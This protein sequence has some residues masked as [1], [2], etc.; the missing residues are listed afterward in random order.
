MTYRRC[1]HNDARSRWLF[2]FDLI[3]VPVD[4]RAAN[5]FPSAPRRDAVITPLFFSSRNR[6]RD[7]LRGSL[8][9]ATRH[10][11][12]RLAGFSGG[13]RSAWE[14]TVSLRYR[15]ASCR[16][17]TRPRRARAHAHGRPP[18]GR[19]HNH[20]VWDERFEQSPPP[21]PRADWLFAPARRVPRCRTRVSSRAR[22]HVFRRLY[23]CRRLVIA[24]TRGHGSPRS[25]RVFRGERLVIEYLE[26]TAMIILIVVRYDVFG[27]GRSTSP[28][29]RRRRP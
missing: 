12:P 17:V 11:R 14:A 22:D 19:V 21:P 5:D 9:T 4:R 20:R 2:L 25:A 7:G 3:R 6:K 1:Q 15:A 27:P 10:A 16:H 23:H 18:R 24:A 28:V 26:T 13:R 29:Y 8:P